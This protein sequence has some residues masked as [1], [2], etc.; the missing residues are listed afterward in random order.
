MLDVQEDLRRRLAEALAPVD[1]RVDVPGDR[2]A[3]LVTVER[4]GGGWQD[5]LLDS[6]G[7]GIYAYA[8]SEAEAS[9]LA[10]RVRDVMRS[11]P[12]DGGYSLV[13][14]ESARRDPDPD[15]R[16]PRWYLSY[17]LKTYD[18]EKERRYGRA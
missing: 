14:E 11:L 10:Q 12:F 5:A 4:E 2:P 15:T 9:D 3:R 8:E 13:T 16:S 17:T 6:P 18:P 7:V 1:V